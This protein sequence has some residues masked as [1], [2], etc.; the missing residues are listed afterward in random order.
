[1]LNLKLEELP[2]VVPTAE[3]ETENEVVTEAA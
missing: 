3:E 2:L 1:M